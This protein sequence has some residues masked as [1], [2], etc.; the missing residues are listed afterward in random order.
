MQQQQQQPPSSAA[1]A[2]APY[3]RVIL[4]T[5]AA[6]FIGSAVAI[7]LVRTYPRYMVVGYDALT[8]AGTRRNLLEIA[9][10]ANFVLVEGDIRSAAL[11]RHVLQQYRVDTIMHFAA[12]TH[13]DNSFGSNSLEFTETNVVGTHVLLECARHHGSLLKLFVAVSSDEVYGGENNE[14]CREESTLLA[15][16][17][18]YAATKSASEHLVRAY[19]KSFGLPVIISR[20]NNVVGPR[21]FPEKLVP[22]FIYLLQQGRPCPIHGRG[23]SRRS[24]LYVD[25]VARAFDVLLHRGRIGETYNIG[26]PR[27]YT[28]METYRKLVEL[29]QI[30][31]AAAECV[32][33]RDRN[34]NDPRYL[35]DCS[36]MEALGWRASTSFDEA[37]RRTI[38]WYRQHPQHFGNVDACLQAH[39]ADGGGKD[40]SDDDSDAVAAPTQPRLCAGYQ[41]PPSSPSG[42]DD[43]NSAAAAVAEPRV[44]SPSSSAY[45]FW[46]VVGGQL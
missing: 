14:P 4:L 31:N 15:P 12:C 28:V 39:P 19:H 38:A 8:Y 22:K 33:V 36:K 9:D 24:F 45:D 17:N 1:T 26:S 6:G 35:V 32:H 13:V 43:S 5:G 3:D 46:G 30:N 25:D 18:P 20:G 27:E 40:D 37:L 23:E 44:M 10:A 42:S 16:S 41:C 11:V 34:F 2:V 21:Q 7:H 29:M